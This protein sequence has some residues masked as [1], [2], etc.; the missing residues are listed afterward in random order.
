MLVFTGGFHVAYGFGLPRKIFKQR[1]LPYT[2]VLPTTPEELEENEPQRMDVDF[3]ELPLYLADYLWCIPYR[4]RKDSRVRLGVQLEDTE[5]GVKIM[6]VQPG[7]AAA[8]AG[9]KPGDLIKSIDDQSVQNSQDVQYVVLSKNQG[10]YA[11][12]VLLRGDRELAVEVLF[13]AQVDKN[14]KE[15]NKK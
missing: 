6:L 2:V 14:L 13:T 8:A 15:K 3:P 7:S 10:D 12:L 5:A 1:K 9:I 11:H 4:N